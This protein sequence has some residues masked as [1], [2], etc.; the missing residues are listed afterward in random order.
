MFRSLLFPP[1]YPRWGG[2]FIF[3]HIPAPTPSH[4]LTGHG[5]GRGQVALRI[6][7]ECDFTD[8]SSRVSARCVSGSGRGGVHLSGLLHHCCRFDRHL[9]LLPYKVKACKAGGKGE[10]QEEAVN[11]TMPSAA[12]A[13]GPARKSRST[14]FST[15]HTKRSHCFLF[16]FPPFVFLL[17]QL[18]NRMFGIPPTSLSLEIF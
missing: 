15:T 12:A 11:V 2:V 1:K 4:W 3:F 10:V 8:G 6:W 17:T 18:N 9:N 5:W 16:I 14:A 13:T 7:R